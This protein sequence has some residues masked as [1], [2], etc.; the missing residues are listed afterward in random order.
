MLPPPPALGGGGGG[1]APKPPESSIRT[2]QCRRPRTAGYYA[3]PDA[4]SRKA[5]V[6]HPGAR[7]QFRGRSASSQPGSGRHVDQSRSN[8]GS[9]SKTCSAPRSPQNRNH[10]A[11]SSVKIPR[12]TA[13][14]S[15][16]SSFHDHPL[17][18]GGIVTSRRGSLVSKPAAERV[19]ASSWVT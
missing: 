5:R 8:G 7:S 13:S 1:G 16:S 9:R 14:P 6:D 12:A 4:V 3:R 2:P 18:S 17:R 19:S 15:S 11:S 10:A